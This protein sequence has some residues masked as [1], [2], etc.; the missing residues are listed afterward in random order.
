MQYWLNLFT[1]E[2]WEEF[3]RSGA[4]VCGFR[5][6]TWERD[7][8]RIAPGDIFL[9]YMVAV[10]RWVG[11]LEIT[12]EAYRDT[13]PIFSAEAFPIR[14]N[15]KP[16]VL[17]PPEHGVPI[18]E[19]GL[20]LSFAEDIKR[21]RWSGWVRTG[22]TEYHEADGKMIVSAVREAKQ[23]PVYREV[24]AWDLKRSTKPG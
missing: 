2:T 5:E 11:A 3:R 17:L 7:A 21:G 10:T 19:L 12:S 23:N 6:R 22:L 4:K 8:R 14:F 18:K 24:H 15:V 13:T 20:K 9:C 16:L 1:G